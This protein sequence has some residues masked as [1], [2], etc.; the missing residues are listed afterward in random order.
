M[1]RAFEVIGIFWA[2]FWRYAGA[3]DVVALQQSDCA[4]LQ[5]EKSAAQE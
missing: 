5:R 3:I 4:F 2:M 1:F